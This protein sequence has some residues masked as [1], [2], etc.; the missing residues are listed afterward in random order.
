M[1]PKLLQLQRQLA[2][3]METAPPTGGGEDT[4]R[5]FAAMKATIEAE[6][7]AAVEVAETRQ[8]KAEN[9]TAELRKVVEQLHRDI[10]QVQK[11]TQSRLDDAVQK[12]RAREQARDQQHAQVVSKLQAELASLHQDLSKEQQARVQAQAQYD[13]AERM[14]AKAMT[15]TAPAPMPQIV[16]PPMAKPCG[17]VANVSKRTDDGR[18]ASMTFTPTT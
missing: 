4:G 2:G 6:V 10:A 17:F 13:T 12:E 1:T 7:A 14:H 3:S 9:E 18:I 15:K 8:E 5:F 16:M 11:D